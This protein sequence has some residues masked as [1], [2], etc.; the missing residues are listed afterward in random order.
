MKGEHVEIAVGERVFIVG[1]RETG[2]A[3]PFRAIAGLWPWGS[4]FLNYRGVTNR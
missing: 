4:T 2:K 3:L 1:A